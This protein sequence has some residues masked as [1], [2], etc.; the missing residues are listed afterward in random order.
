MSASALDQAESMYKNLTN[1]K[2]SLDKYDDEDKDIVEIDDAAY[3][4]NDK[5]DE[6]I[7]RYVFPKTRIKDR[8][9]GR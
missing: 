1:L 2:Q 7:K 6:W 9:K 4:I 5:I 3:D 8:E